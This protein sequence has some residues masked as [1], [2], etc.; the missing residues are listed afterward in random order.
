MARDEERQL[1]VPDFWL[2]ECGNACRNRV[3]RGWLPRSAALA[4]YGQF[5]KMPVVRMDTAHLLDHATN[6]AL[7][8]NMTAYD[9][10]YVATAQYVGGTL[11]TADARLVEMLQ[12]TELADV[13]R[14]VSAW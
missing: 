8:R 9:A 12:P 2:L 5:K 3:A 10:L 7:A 4:A 6:L 14:H 13:V 11:V 1:V